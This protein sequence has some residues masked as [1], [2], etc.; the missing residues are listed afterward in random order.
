M[1]LIFINEALNALVNYRLP[2]QI[3]V[4]WQNFDSSGK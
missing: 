4:M 2:N 1:S 3:G